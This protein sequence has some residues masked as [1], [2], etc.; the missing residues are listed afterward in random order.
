[1]FTNLFRKGVP[2]RIPRHNPNTLLKL[3]CPTPSTS[4]S[5]LCKPAASDMKTFPL[6][7][8]SRFYAAT[9]ATS[10]VPI[11]KIRNIGISAH[12]DSGKTTVTERVLFYTG[13]IK[14]I[15]EVRGKDGVG[16]KMDSMELER[17]KGITIQSAAT[18]TTWKDHNIN[19][20]DTPGHVDFTI[21][22]ERALRVL[23]GA[24]LVLCA[25]SGVQ[26]QTMTVDRQMKRY[27]VPCVA[28][29]N[30]CDRAGANPRRVTNQ[31][32]SKL[33]HNAALIQIP[34]GL[35]NNFEGVVDL[36]RNRAVY[37]DGEG[38]SELRFAD[39]PEDLAEAV[40][41]HR[42]ELVEALANVDDEVMDRFLDSGDSSFESFPEE[43]LS[44]AIRRCTI[45]RS[46][47]PVLLG[48][49]LKN[50][51]VQ[52]V[53]DAVLDY[54]PNPGEVKNIGLDLNNNEAE[55]ELDPTRAAS[56]SDPAP[57]N[58]FVGLAFKLEEG[59]YGQLTYL[60]CYQGRLKRGD[61]IVN[62]RTN[63]RQKI[64]R[65]V[66]MHSDEMEDVQSVQA[67]D[68]C[69]LFGL[70]C[71]SGDSFIVQPAN[72]DSFRI[73]MSSMFVPDP[74]ISL[75]IKP[76]KPSEDLDKFSKALA[77][78]QRE[79]PTFRV[80]VDEESRETII[81]GMGELH[82]DVY[83]ERMLREYNC[84]T[85]TG[86]PKVAFREYLSQTVPF[87]YTHKKQSGGS[88]QYGRVIGKLEPIPVD[89]D[90][91]A[92]NLNC[93]PEFVN[94]TVG[95]NIPPGFITAIEKGFHEACERG[96]LIGHPVTGVRMV[97]QDGA[98]H[99]VDSNEIAFRLAARGAVR[100]C[101]EKG[102]PVVLEPVM[103]VEITV[104]SEFQGDVM[105]GI[106]RRKGMVTDSSV[107]DGFA[108]IEANV[109][110]NEMFGYSTELRSASEGKG[111]YSMEY[112]KHSPVLPGTQAEM[113][114][115]F[116]KEQGRK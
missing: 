26:S 18:Y 107:E 97:L 68:I 74:V 41:Q 11:E 45:A 12:I 20:I 58:P 17:E 9:A 87:D 15:H 2:L 10:T 29:I 111:E 90:N 79:D 59:R 44:K 83:I 65:L 104:P 81:S 70:E 80:N 89:E 96:T 102:N 63:Q 56:D 95:N 1:M 22:V 62:T 24:V 13:R 78:F 4:T 50:K 48:S 39:V 93:E 84:P 109:P 35:D 75:S 51:G 19:I 31:L 66:R 73:S 88:G 85:T 98:A 33:R 92:S 64:P 72:A 49:A 103:K 110:L 6:I 67:G 25:A 112:F 5:S 3:V 21:E 100:Q 99:A 52:E 32:K 23:D 113:I 30:K 47:T 57:P 77:R 16:A 53:L 69:A 94:E 76:N 42:A 61:F 55:V 8:H 60:R 91:P 7:S 114:S 108:S 46:F 36:L 28:F 14:A 40:E 43:F 86:R 54:L 105:G 37:F 38:G 27:A 101:Y 106:N 116:K 71:A 82:L 115:D 34:I